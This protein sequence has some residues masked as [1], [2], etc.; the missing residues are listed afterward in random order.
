M[1]ILRF[2]LDNAQKQRATVIFYLV[3]NDGNRIPGEET[4]IVLYMPKTVSVSDGASYGKVELGLL[5]NAAADAARAGAA[6]GDAG[7][8]QV[9][10]TM[11]Q[12]IVDETTALAGAGM[13]DTT[14]SV[15]KVLQAAGFYRDGLGAGVR[16]GLGRTPHPHQRSI[17]DGID[18]RSFTFDFDMVPSSPEEA[19]RIKQ[20]VTFFRTKLYPLVSPG[21]LTYIHPDKFRIEYRYYNGTSNVAIAHK[22]KPC[23]LT[24]VKTTY[25]PNGEQAFHEGG[26]F[27][28]TKVE[29][30]FQ[31]ER[32][33][34]R[35]DIR[36]GY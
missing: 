34:E 11:A 4:A 20:I 16:A 35:D 23:F 21:G 3:D 30:S 19:V 25:N 6:Q 8:G 9:A 13:S 24:S 28:S 5:G 22:I 10:Q 33:L 17:F 18:L 31:E 26:D 1:G 29:I 12:S 32:A 7:L 36:S 15:T 2:P 27:I 14:G